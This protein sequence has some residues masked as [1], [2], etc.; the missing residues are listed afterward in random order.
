MKE[1]AIQITGNIIAVQRYKKEPEIQRW[2]VFIVIYFSG[3][4]QTQNRNS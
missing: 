3:L 4:S 1:T 2:G